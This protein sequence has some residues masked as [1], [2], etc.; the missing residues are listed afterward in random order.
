MLTSARARRTSAF[1]GER[2]EIGRLILAFGLLH[3][4]VRYWQR[5]CENVV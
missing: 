2:D 1:L 4:N 5:L 3:L